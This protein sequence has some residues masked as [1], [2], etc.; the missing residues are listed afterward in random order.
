MIT[1]VKGYTDSAL[2]LRYLTLGQIRSD[3]YETPA[4]KELM[5]LVRDEILRRI[6][7]GEHCSP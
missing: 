2:M 7:S 1:N 4:S 3:G 5:R 6:S